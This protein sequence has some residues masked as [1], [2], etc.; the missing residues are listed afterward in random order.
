MRDNNFQVIFYEIECYA[1]GSNFYIFAALY[2]SLLDLLSCLQ[3]RGTRDCNQ[4]SNGTLIF[5]HRIMEV[6]DKK[7]YMK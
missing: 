4:C 6:K 1:R 2:F 7:V 3:A 5:E